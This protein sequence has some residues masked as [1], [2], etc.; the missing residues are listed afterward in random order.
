[1]LLSLLRSF[2]SVIDWRMVGSMVLCHAL[3]AVMMRSLLGHRRSKRGTHHGDLL[4]YNATALLMNCIC[5]YIGI[6]GYLEGSVAACS[7]SMH[8]R[9]YKYSSRFAHLTDVTAAYE[10]Y[11]TF[12]VATLPEY[13]NLPFLGHHA[14]TFTLALLSRA[15]YCNYYGFFFFGVSMVS[16]APL[17]V[18]EMTKFVDAPKTHQAARLAFAGAFLTLRSVVWPLVSARFWLDSLAVLRSPAG[19][20]SLFATL[21]FLVSNV[22]LT[23]LQ[24]LWT[25]KIVAGLK[26]A[27]APPRA[28]KKARDSDS[29]VS[30]DSETET[31]TEMRS[32]RERKPLLRAT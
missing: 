28:R 9:L 20:H 22:G 29:E 8:D 4:A 15:P 17:A 13:A 5:A 7:G 23:G 11:N 26:K 18:V 19:P 27:L 14:T 12:A 32:R 6:T 30:G 25:T 24:L 3:L 31:D 21:F 1:M 10:L 2:V 16:S